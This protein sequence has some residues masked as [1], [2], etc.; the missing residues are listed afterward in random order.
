MLE[1]VEALRMHQ[2]AVDEVDEAAT[3]YLGLNRTDTRCLDIIERMGRVTA[4]QLAAETGLTTGAITAALD[5]LEGA[6]YVR[7]V[8]DLTDRRRVLVEITDSGLRCAMDCYGPIATEGQASLE[9]LTE[10]QLELIRDFMRAGYELLTNHAA[11]VRAMA[12]DAARPRAAAR[13]RA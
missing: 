2:N 10:E 3:E 6:G 1:V 4:G 5:R 13:D 9:A 11:R 12:R 7:R 8:R